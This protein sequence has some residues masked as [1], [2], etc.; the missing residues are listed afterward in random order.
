MLMHL[1]MTFIC[2]MEAGS[3]FLMLKSYRDCDTVKQAY[4]ISHSVCEITNREF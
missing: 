4:S 1:V 2:N 3:L